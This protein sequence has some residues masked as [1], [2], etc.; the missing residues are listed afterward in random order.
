MTKVWEPEPWQQEFVDSIG[1]GDLVIVSMPRMPGKTAT[2]AEMVKDF[3]SGKVTSEMV[4]YVS[5]QPDGTMRKE[6][7][8]SFVARVMSQH[9]HFSML[10]GDDS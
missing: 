7:Y 8:R 9:T 1:R 4:F 2:M 3:M 5:I 6:Y 10:D